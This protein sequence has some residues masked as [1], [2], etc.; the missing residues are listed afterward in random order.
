MAVYR[1]VTGTVLVDGKPEPN[2]KAYFY[3]PGTTTKINVYQD[4]GVTPA[5]NPQLTDA[6]GRYAVFL[7]VA[8]YP[9]VRIYLEKD[10]V[11][12]SETNADLDGIH[13]TGEVTGSGT[14]N[15]LP[16]WIAETGLGNS[17]LH[18]DASSL[19]IEDLSIKF[20][21]DGGALTAFDLP[22]SATPAAGTEESYAFKIDGTIIA[23]I[24]AEANGAGGIQNARMA[25]SEIRALDA[26]GLKLFDAA[27]SGIFVKDGGSVGIGTL[28]PEG[29]LYVS[30]GTSAT[31]ILS[32]RASPLVADQGG[33]LH[34]QGATYAW[35]EATV[36]TNGTS[37]RLTFHYVERAN[38]ATKVKTNVLTLYGTGQ[39]TIG[40]N[41]IIDNNL[42]V[43]TSSQ[44]GG[45]SKVIGIANATTVPTSNPTGG[46]ILYVEG[47]AGKWRG[48]SGTVT[49]FGP[50]EPYCPVCGADFMIE[51]KN[52]KY[53]HL[54][55]CMNCLAEA[56][57]EQPWIIR[58]NM[59]I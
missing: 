39:V 57:G 40:G 26:T 18:V 32:I 19:H 34:H 14:A 38:P 44:F 12:F 55:M 10:G 50:A 6:A 51:F 58:E 22:V 59:R 53:G 17:P 37:G 11:D 21:Q 24:Y 20:K 15:Y 56:L 9:E 3:Q 46:G 31:D 5:D 8:Q 27:G 54:K 49:T 36:G 42:G 23:K 41:G 7:D 45:G 4:K 16:K 30:T 47:G 35:Q 33:V 29:R 2:V 13:V 43:G 28:T 25:A 52:P 48:S 1:K